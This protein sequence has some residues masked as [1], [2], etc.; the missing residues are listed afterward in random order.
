MINPTHV[1]FDNALAGTDTIRV[2]LGA[3]SVTFNSG[4]AESMPGGARA[5]LPMGSVYG[6]SVLQNGNYA[7]VVTF[8]NAGGESSSIATEDLTF[9]RPPFSPGVVS[10]TS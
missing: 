3:V 7:P 1:Y 6:D 4:V 10:H 8:I 2:T 5:R 9:V